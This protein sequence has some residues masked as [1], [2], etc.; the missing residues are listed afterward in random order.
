MSSY[1]HII[2]TISISDCLVPVFDLRPEPNQKTVDNEAAT[3]LLS[4]SMLSE[5]TGPMAMGLLVEAVDGK[6]NIP[7]DAIL[8]LARTN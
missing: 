2:G 6:V 4:V 8:N 3:Y 7:P 5:A 1:P